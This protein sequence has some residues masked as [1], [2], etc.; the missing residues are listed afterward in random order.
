MKIETIV[1]Y[2]NSPAA[3]TAAIYAATANLNPLLIEPIEDTLNS[4]SS[5]DNNPN[6]KTLNIITPNNLIIDTDKVIGYKGS[7]FI[8][9]CRKQA[10][11]FRVRFVKTRIRSVEDKDGIVFVDGEIKTK[12][13]IVDCCGICITQGTVDSIIKNDSISKD[14]RINKNNNIDKNKIVN[15]DDIVNKNEN[16]DS[17]NNDSNAR[18]GHI[19]YCGLALGIK[20]AVL[21]AA[22]GCKA[23]IDA[24]ALID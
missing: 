14:N 22:S 7:D 6:N 1:I 15:K 21:N 11:K 13:L 10:S 17:T 24:K 5:I 9:D 8:G 3:Y 16:A 4:N 18:K 12:V 23:A 2:G 19:I 20:E